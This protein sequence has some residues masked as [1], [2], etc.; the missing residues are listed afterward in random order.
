[1]T[2]VASSGPGAKG[3]T[4]PEGSGYTGATA[5]LGG[6]RVAVVG[7]G[8]PMETFLDRLLSGL[9]ARGASL[10]VVSR[11]AP[12][13]SWL[14][15]RS[16]R[17]RYGP[18]PRQARPLARLARAGGAVPA[19]RTFGD[20]FVDRLRGRVGPGDAGWARRAV[21]D[22]D[23]VYV[24]WINTLIDW[25]ELFDAGPPVVTS[26]RGRMITVDPWHPSDPARPAELRAVFDRVER[27][28]CVS[29]AMGREAMAFGLHPDRSTVITPAVDPAAFAPRDAG[30]EPGP[31]RVV[32]TGSLTW[33]KDQEH[34]LRGIRRAVDLGADFRYE[35][36]GDGVERD[37]FRFTAGELGLAGRV[38]LAGRRSPAQVF[39]HLRS[40]DV[41]LHTSCTEGISNAV[42]EA[43]SC[44]LPVVT[45]E[46][47]GMAEAVRHDVDGLLVG[48]R[49]PAAVGAALHRLATEPDTRARLGRAARARIVD[50]FRL[51][52]QLDAFGALLLDAAGTR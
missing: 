18:G 25:P 10:E 41:F 39:E 34:A 44:G 5:P 51:D 4:G 13:V 45:T 9:A 50:R 23:V 32:A 28:H 6:L 40:A 17:W 48:V 16:A 22:A 15:E 33:L 7:V 46:A 21:G 27:V 42:L 37:R 12:P 11:V 20:L 43:M 29:E 36:V 3:D 24:P 52:Q 14:G 35:V 31:V 49:D 47:G 19:G 38:G 30:R 1:M 8:V 2:A 26:C